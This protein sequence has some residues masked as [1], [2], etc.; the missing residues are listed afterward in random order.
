M[1]KADAKLT[2]LIAELV[3]RRPGNAT[4]GCMTTPSAA[5][6]ENADQIFK[7]KALEAIKQDTT[8]MASNE[9]HKYN[10]TWL[11]HG[12]TLMSMYR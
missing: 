5:Q 4:A 10:T 8:K 6:G 9:D 11:D 1:H 2:A 7:E 12:R 3:K